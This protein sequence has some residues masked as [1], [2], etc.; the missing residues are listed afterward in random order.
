MKFNF[1]QLVFV[2]SAG[3]FLLLLTNKY[4]YS[5]LDKTD[6]LKSV[7][8]FSEDIPNGKVLLESQRLE[9]VSEDSSALTL[10]TPQILVDIDPVTIEEYTIFSRKTGRSLAYYPFLI[11]GP[12]QKYSVL[13]DGYP[14]VIGTPEQ[15]LSYCAWRGERLLMESEWLVA[16]CGT[17]GRT[18]PWGE[19]WMSGQANVNSKGVAPIDQFPTD[20]GA[21]GIRGV[22][23]NV[24]DLVMI[25]H[26][27]GA[28]YALRGGG[29]DI[30]ELASRCDS[31]I[32]LDP[33]YH[34]FVSM[35]IGFRC[36]KV[37]EKNNE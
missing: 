6:N 36:A 18:Y 12:E 16:A 21:L 37:I 23:G 5:F 2:L 1:A 11:P 28:R 17:D 7:F 15:A 35:Q 20:I 4:L 13:E 34:Q 10:T 27:T 26:P 24:M 32:V 9:L 30:T 14:V 3:C 22:V 31:R 25:D 29:W 8:L 33:S 19:Q